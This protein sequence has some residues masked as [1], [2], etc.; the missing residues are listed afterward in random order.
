MAWDT[1][2]GA[3][4]TRTVTAPPVKRPK[5]AN[6]DDAPDMLTDRYAAAWA[7]GF[8]ACRKRWPK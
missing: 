8:N 5:K 1:H 4:V 2:I 3:P 6:A 7:M